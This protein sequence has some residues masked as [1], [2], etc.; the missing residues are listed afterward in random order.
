VKWWN[1]LL[2]L[3]RYPETHKVTRLRTCSCERR[4]HGVQNALTTDTAFRDSLVMPSS[5]DAALWYPANHTIPNKLPYASWTRQYVEIISG[6]PGGGRIVP[7]LNRFRPQADR[8]AHVEI[9]NGHGHTPDYI[10]DLLTPVTDIPT[11]S[12]LCSSSNGN[13]FL[14]GTERRFGDRAFS[15]AAPRVWNRL[16]TEL[17]LMRS[18]TT[19]F[20]HHL[21]TFLFNSA[22]SFHWL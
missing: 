21:K 19:T 12:S 14:P 15:V 5:T 2:L 10:S 20:K 7:N 9:N 6:P 18:S 17:K 1:S 13:L 16:P 11:R 3:L 22:H 8:S 4:G